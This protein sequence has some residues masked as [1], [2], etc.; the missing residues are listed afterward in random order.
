MLAGGSDESNTDPMA[1]GPA[2]GEDWV[3]TPPHLMYMVPGGF[4]TRYFTTDHMS[5]YPYIMWAGTDLEHIMIPVA[6][7]SM[8]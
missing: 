1:T 3:T 6:D 5:G 2:A 7:M 4:D 8:P